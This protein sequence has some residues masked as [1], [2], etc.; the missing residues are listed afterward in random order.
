MAERVPCKN[1][2]YTKRAL[3]FAK[4]RS[5]A[6]I[7]YTDFDEAWSLCKITKTKSA[8]GDCRNT[9]QAGWCTKCVICL[10]YQR[11]FKAQTISLTFLI[12]GL[13]A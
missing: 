6:T 13:V 3:A 11:E 7:R 4:N 2:C 10:K 1:G 12:N 8:S 9:E 5:D